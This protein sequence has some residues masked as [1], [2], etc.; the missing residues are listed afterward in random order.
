MWPSGRTA[1]CTGL[2]TPPLVSL[3]PV[4]GGYLSIL[5]HLVREAL[6]RQRRASVPTRW[7]HWPSPCSSACSSTRTRWAA[8]PSLHPCWPPPPGIRPSVFTTPRTSRS[9]P[10]LLCRVTGTGFTAAAS[11]RAAATCSAAP[12]TARWSC[13]ARGQVRCQRCCSTR[14]AARSECAHWRRTPP[15]C[16]PG[17][18][19]APWPSGTSPARHCAGTVWPRVNHIMS[20]CCLPL[21]TEGHNEKWSPEMI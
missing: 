9:S 18:A 8:A 3:F 13:G 11:A 14:A 21:I 2:I 15:Y 5:R 1:V 20:C 19:M 12:R 6:P 7:C 4:T 10:A 16:W 17:P